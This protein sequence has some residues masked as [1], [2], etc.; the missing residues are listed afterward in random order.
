MLTITKPAGGTLSAAGAGIRCG[1]RGSDCTASRPNG[2]LIELTPEADAGFTFSG[3]IGDCAPGGRTIMTNAARTCGGTFVKIESAGPPPGATQTLTIAP[4][5]TGGTLE[6][7]DILCGTKGTVCSAN[8]SRRRGGRNCI[9]PPI[10]T[11]RSWDSRA[12][13]FRSAT[14]R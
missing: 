9:R 11:T 7:V 1:T 4:M 8:P 13:A 12:T 6:G 14:R 3:Y 2:E 5:P 10:P